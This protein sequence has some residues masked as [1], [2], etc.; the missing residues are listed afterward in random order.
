MTTKR[1][2]KK[3][4][5]M[6]ESSERSSRTLIQLAHAYGVATA[7]TGQTGEF[8][9]ISDQVLIEVLKALNVDAST[10]A[11]A[12][13]ALRSKL[14]DDQK[15]LVKPTVLHVA[16]MDSKVLLH[17][18]PQNTTAVTIRLEDG[19][20][21]QDGA[22]L[23]LRTEEEPNTVYA[24]IPSDLP[25][26]YHSLIVSVD[27]YDTVAHL[28]S[29][30][31]KID[32]I[33]PLKDGSLW[34][35]MAQLYSVRSEDSWGVGDFDDLKNML[36]DAKKKTGADFILINPVH[37]AEPISPLTPSPYLP[38]S[39]RF[40]NFTYIRPEDIAEYQSLTQADKAAVENLHDQAKIL[41]EN[42]NRI[43]RDAMWDKKRQALWT[44]FQAERSA[45]RQKE[46]ED[47]CSREGEDLEAYA[48]WCLAYDKWGA[49]TSSP[50][51]WEKTLNKD[52]AEVKNLRAQNSQS[53][54][55]YKWMEWIATSQLAVAQKA[56]Q[57]AGMKIGIMSDMAVGVHPQGAEVW[58]NP[59]RFA[60]GA[61][62]GA[63][64]DM[65]NQQGQDW[66]Q[67][68]LNPVNL[69]ETGYATYRTMVA[70]IFAKAG[71]V[72]IDHILG[73][74]RLWWIPE[75]R[76]ADQGTYVQY[77]SSI[78]LG[79]LA[80]E[81]SRVGGTVVG[82][83]LGVVPDYVADSLKSHGLMGCVIEW[84]QQ[85]DGEFVPPKQWRQMA[86]ASVT[87]HDMPPTAGYLNY[88]HVKIRENLGLLTVPAKQFRASAEYEHK[89]L[90]S[91]L[92]DN[93]YLDKAFTK[94]EK[95]HEQE[96]VEAMHRAL[97][98]S[99]SKLKAA[100]LVDAVGERRA[101]NQPGTNNEY[102]NW[103]IPLADDKGHA[104]YLEDLFDLPRAR[105]LAA[106]MNGEK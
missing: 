19:S 3:K 77:D 70:G 50:D 47:Y 9:E 2:T 12:A 15:R 18:S 20:L 92:V 46:F 58:W 32:L 39:R 105:S 41:N 24:V 53:L 64:P 85:Y 4:V 88:E 91:M 69:E 66:S 27:G 28:I 74:F 54:E 61:T 8:N 11:K 30:P 51:C 33:D 5:K 83:D 71:A 42:P 84:Y 36:V 35:W 67:P 73:L 102:P 87:T 80:L 100:A 1:N 29:V 44:I 79:I 22:K 40:I 93:G 23:D 63:P 95:V 94:N 76:T 21:Y 38:I 26:G 48:T 65:F 81:A 31:E 96:I 97:L 7:Y 25:L 82:E 37:A 101:Q 34:G 55:F 59:E 90:L 43:D 68:P 72:R 17:V 78:M 75:G 104:V 52:S 86:L 89:Q 106:V 6:K 103:R 62:V 99:P 10:E 14:D 49:P 57:Q 56:A 16:G 13:K 60:S 98:D 45:R